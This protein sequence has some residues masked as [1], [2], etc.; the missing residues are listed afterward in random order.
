MR[1]YLREAVATG[2]RWTLEIQCDGCGSIFSVKGE[3]CV[4][5]SLGPPRSLLRE[6]EGGASEGGWTLA[7]GGA[8][9]PFLL[10]DCCPSSQCRK[11]YQPAANTN[12]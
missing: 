5:P 7:A 3:A 10:A 8:A 9:L 4:L 11:L 1:T 12:T 2:L 6:L